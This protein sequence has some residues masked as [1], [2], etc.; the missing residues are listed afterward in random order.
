MRILT[1]SNFY[2]PH[3]FGGYELGCLAVMEALKQRGHEVAVLTTDYHSRSV[4]AAQEPDIHRI[5]QTAMRFDG[6]AGPVPASTRFFDRQSYNERAFARLCHE[7]RPDVVYCWNMQHVPI[8]LPIMAQAMGIPVCAFVSDP[9]L[10]DWTSD[11]WHQQCNYAPRTVQGQGRKFLVRLYGRLRGVSDLRGRRLHLRHA[12]FASAFLMRQAREKGV[13]FTGEKVIHWGIDTGTYRFRQGRNTA[14][15]SGALPRLLYV[16]QIGPHK[17]VH[18]TVE[19]MNLVVRETACRNARLT[20]VGGEGF[21]PDYNRALRETVK[22]LFLEDNIE[23][24]GMRTREQLVSIYQEHDILILPS[25]W[26]EPFAITPLEA[27]ASGLAVTAT[28]TGGSPEILVDNENALL[29]PAGNARVLA[30]HLIR[31]LSDEEFLDRLR[32]HGRKTIEARFTF[33]N[34]VDQVE[35]CLRDFVESEVGHGRSTKPP[36]PVETVGY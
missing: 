20:V 24:L 12:Q 8:S 2:P 22:T 34:M 5:L 1:L 29:F 19:A 18:T 14:R 31:L 6:P 9:W 32:C 33:E 26:D 16:G 25:I 7:Y 21:F 30:D 15:R 11:A 13:T 23:F 35:T 10:S 17:G 28:P 3:Y 27:M 4:N 36:V